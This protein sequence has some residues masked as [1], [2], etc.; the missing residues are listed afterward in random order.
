MLL[1]LN[2]TW[3]WTAI[4][5]I[6]LNRV[7]EPIPYKVVHLSVSSYCISPSNNRNDQVRITS[8]R[9]RESQSIS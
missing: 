4:R 9:V 5:D 2:T 1:H 6:F 7:V 3:Q 8:G